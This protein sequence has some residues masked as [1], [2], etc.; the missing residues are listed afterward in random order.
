MLRAMGLAAQW[1]GM[2]RE[3]PAGWPEIG[4]RLRLA[5]PEDAARAAALLGLLSPGVADGALHLRVTSHGAAGPGV[6]RRL[7]SRLD[8]ERIGGT[9]ELAR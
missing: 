8:E 1:D 6:A 4:L 7:L 5:R 3:L 9:L 2:L